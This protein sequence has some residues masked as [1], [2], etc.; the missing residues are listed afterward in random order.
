MNEYVHCNRCAGGRLPHGAHGDSNH[1]RILLLREVLGAICHY[2]IKHHVSL[3]WIAGNA[4]MLAGELHK[5]FEGTS[6]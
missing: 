1:N 4:L 5:S 2:Q 3:G 6:C